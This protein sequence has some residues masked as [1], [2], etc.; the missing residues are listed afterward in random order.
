MHDGRRKQARTPVRRTGVRR[1]IAVA[2]VLALGAAGYALTGPV[3]TAS[4]ALSGGSAPGGAAHVWITTADGGKKLQRAD[5]AAFDG[6][7]QDIDI[8]V[9]AGKKG[10]EFTGA[11]A[12]MT[13][14]S[15]HL[16]SGLPQDERDALLKE[17]FSRDG[18]GIGLTFLRQPLGASDFVAAK[19]FYSYEDEQGKFSVDRDTEEIL[20][21]LKQARSV[22][23]GIRVMGTPWSAPG[24]MKDGGRLE[25]GS[26]KPEHYDDYAEYLVKAV[27]AY[28]KEGVPVDYLTAQNEP[29]FE[30]GYPSMKMT[31]AQQADFLK[32]LDSKLGAA[33]LDTELFAYDHNWDHPEYPLDVLAKTKDVKRVAGAAFHC[34]GGEP[35]AQQKVRDAGGR[36]LE[37]E[38]S[39][40]DADDSSQTFA[41]TLKWQTENLVIRSMRAGS[42]TVVPW[43]LAL[44]SKGGPQY[45]NCGT[46]CNGVVEIGDGGD[47][48]AKN[49]EFYVLGHVSK[50][51]DR[52]AH[53]I[54]ST[55]QGSGGLQNV[56][57]ENPDGSRASVVLNASGSSKRFSLTENGKSLDYDLPAGAVAT[58][59]WPGAP[60]N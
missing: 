47:T 56:T 20:P 40:T 14:S 17:L 4:A 7:E 43:N 27:Q 12:S 24:W 51:V 1:V 58:F 38:C 54:A 2:G 8:S 42:E 49:A 29:F 11:G 53:R 6:T 19:P 59:D 9:D 23:S 31:S 32:V 36:V 3:H 57:F 13:E 25:G 55:T 15:A 60:G 26:L 45:G 16:I 39:G 33:G 28:K 46:K 50:F 30:G 34:Y 22:N 52:G 5:D 21:L 48:V 35:E 10:Q 37:T 44:D 41:S 18:S